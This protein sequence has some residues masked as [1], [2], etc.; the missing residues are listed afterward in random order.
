[1]N[2]IRVVIIV[3]VLTGAVTTVSAQK[4][5]DLDSA[6]IADINAAFNSGTLT[7]E[8]LVQLCLARIEAY[9]KHGPSLRALIALNPKALET[10]RQ[11]DAE[12]KAKGPRSPLHGIPVVS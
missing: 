8:K 10:A 6:N 3:A 2:P 11:L 4:R 5:I 7:A 12:R 1:M 9:D